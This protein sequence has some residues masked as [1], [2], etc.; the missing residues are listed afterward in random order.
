MAELKDGK[1]E[2]KEG[3]GFLFFIKNKK[4]PRSPDGR[5]RMLLDGKL[6]EMVVW[7][8]LDMNKEVYYTM[9]IAIDKQK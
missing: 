4:N 1:V 9:E 8:K 5:L 6:V 3:R 2:L 7:R